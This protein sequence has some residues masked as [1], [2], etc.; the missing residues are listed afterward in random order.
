M[1]EPKASTFIDVLTDS[2]AYWSAERLI[3]WLAVLGGSLLCTAVINVFLFDDLAGWLG[4][5]L[6]AFFLLPL[7]MFFLSWKSARYWKD[8]SL[9]NEPARR[10]PRNCSPMVMLAHG[11][12]EQATIITCTEWGIPRDE[13]TQLVHYRARVNRRN[14]L[15]Q[16]SL[17]ISLILFAL[18]SCVL[19]ARFEPESLLPMSLIAGATIATASIFI[20]RGIRG[21]RLFSKP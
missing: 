16:T 3:F 11:K 10:C 8:W 4:L 19:I 21:W 2:A 20:W 9:R 6:V 5:M 13:A 14:H 7:V 12:G 1:D 17:G 15:C 18:G